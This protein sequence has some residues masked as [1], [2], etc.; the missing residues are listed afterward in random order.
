MSMKGR[1]RK[2]TRLRLSYSVLGVIRKYYVNGISTRLRQNICV[3]MVYQC[4][5]N[6]RTCQKI[7]MCIV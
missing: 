5:V 4:L 2:F 3:H 6:F 7:S 1:V